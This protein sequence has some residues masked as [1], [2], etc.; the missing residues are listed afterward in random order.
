[1]PGATCLPL[2]AR[3]YRRGLWKPRPRR[4]VQ[5]VFSACSHESLCCQQS[6]IGSF[7]PFCGEDP[8][9]SGNRDPLHEQLRP[10]PVPGKTHSG[11]Y[12]QRDGRSPVASVRRRHERPRMDIRRRALTCYRDCTGTGDS[13]RGLQHRKW[14]R[15]NKPRSRPR[16]SQVA[17]QVRITHSIR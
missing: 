15:E 4:E 5:R 1:M 3:E 17:R 13:G 8:R 14:L 9:F 7:G 12:Q 2:C 10:F 6:C 11:A 16:S